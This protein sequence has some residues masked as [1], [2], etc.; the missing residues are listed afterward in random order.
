MK[1][2]GSLSITY[3]TNHSKF[4][5]Y[6]S[7]KIL[8]LTRKGLTFFMLIHYKENVLLTIN[9]NNKKWLV[10]LVTNLRYQF[11]K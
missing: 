9:F 1:N 5:V 3:H 10:T 6:I 2:S 11:I 8:Y 4:E 7:Q